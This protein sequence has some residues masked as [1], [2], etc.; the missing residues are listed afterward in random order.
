M[1]WID[2]YEWAGVAIMSGFL[3]MLIMALCVAAKYG[4]H[5]RSSKDTAAWIA[6]L[7]RKY[8]ARVGEP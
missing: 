3:T 6:E 2:I 5:R 7:D 4:P 8:G 1:T